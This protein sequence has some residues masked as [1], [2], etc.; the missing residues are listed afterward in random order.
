[1][2]EKLTIKNF[3][4]IKS[5]ELELGRFNV[6]IGES[7]TGKST[8]AKLLSFCR[9]FSNIEGG[10]F[11]EAKQENKN[12][13]LDEI[14]ERLIKWGLYEYVNDECFV[15]YECDD[16]IFSFSKRLWDSSAGKVQGLLTSNI[17]PKTVRFKKLLDDFHKVN[18]EGYTPFEFYQDSVADI[19]DNPFFIPT[20]R[21][22]Q[23]VF[24]MGKDFTSNLSDPLFKYFVEIDKIERNYRNEVAIEPLNILY[25]NENGV[26]KI[27]KGNESSFYNLINAASGYQSTIPIVLLVNYYIETRKKKKTFIIEEPE[28]NL[29]PASQYELVKFLSQSLYH[30]NQLLLTTHS[31]Y[32]LTSLNNLMYAYKVGQDNKEEI[33]KIIEEKYWVNPNIVCAYQLLPDGTC[34]NIISEDGLTMAEKIDSVSR[35]INEEFDLIQDIKLSV[36]N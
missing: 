20:E 6:L 26:G 10:Y 7:A 14:H 2:D 27:K 31:P 32:I 13:G 34:E 1:M 30:H 9:Y 36:K 15:K 3:G 16:Y 24:S 11:D 21:G 4:P 5:V 23:S 22:L 29:F 35:K 28:L 17:K 25:K 19:L 12:H 33:S 8:V 18:H